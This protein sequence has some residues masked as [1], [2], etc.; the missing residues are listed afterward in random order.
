M[1]PR[2]STTQTQRRHRKQPHLFIAAWLR[3]PMKMGAV[4]PSSRA[5]ARALVDQIDL[6]RD[7]MIIEL[8]AGKGVVTHALMEGGIP[9]D[10]LLIVEREKQLHALLHASFHEL[11]VICADAMELDRVIAGM[12]IEKVNA[13]VSSLPLISMPSAIRHAIE[14]QMADAI[15]EQG[16]IIQY[17][18]GTK[19]P[20][21][22]GELKRYGLV[23]QRVKLVLANVPPAHVWVY[24]KT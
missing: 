10:R 13:I 15:G 5:L 21:S 1:L 6:S 23:G 3:A 24:K 2:I 18:Y 12:G 17:T 19:S 22:P 9:H 8:G 11:E 20:I 16:M 4:L 7:G 14:Q